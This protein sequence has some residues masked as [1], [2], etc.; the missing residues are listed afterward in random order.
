MAKY[1]RY[2]PGV[3]NSKPLKTLDEIREE[4]R[5]KRIASSR[6]EF[7]VD[8]DFDTAAE[9]IEKFDEVEAFVPGEI[10]QYG[11]RRVY[12]RVFEKHFFRAEGYA[13]LSVF[14]EESERFGVDILAVASGAGQGIYNLKSGVNEDFIRE[15]KEYLGLSV[16]KESLMKKAK[17]YLFE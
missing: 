15:F 17:R 1:E 12:F 3:D 7:H 16:P 5:E 10:R 9:K 2:I 11:D 4:E 13:S 6:Y 14:M 8:M